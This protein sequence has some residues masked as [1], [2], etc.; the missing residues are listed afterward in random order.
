MNL[1]GDIKVTLNANCIRDIML[2]LEDN[3]EYGQDISILKSNLNYPSE[4]LLYTCQKLV[5]SNL[6]VGK[7]NVLG[8]FKIEDITIQ[9]HTFISKLKDN[10]LWKKV[11]SKVSKIAKPLTI[12]TLETI[13]TNILTAS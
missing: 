12:A 1:K 2:H 3:L 9:G 11:L 5:D 4:E 10:K 8:D 13:I 7:R 6:I